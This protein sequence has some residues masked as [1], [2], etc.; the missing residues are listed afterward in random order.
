MICETLQILT[1]F[2]KL[3]KRTGMSIVLVNMAKSTRYTLI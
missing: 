2:M 3:V 1:H